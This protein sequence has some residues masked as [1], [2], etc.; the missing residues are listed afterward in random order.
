MAAACGRGAGC[1]AFP[2]SFLSPGPSRPSGQ[3]SS[4]ARAAGQ[5]QGGA[6]GGT[7]SRCGDRGPPGVRPRQSQKESA[8]TILPLAWAL[9]PAGPEVGC[10]FC[11]CCDIHPDR[12]KP[13]VPKAARLTVRSGKCS[14]VLRGQGGDLRGVPR[15]VKW[16]RLAEE[17]LSCLCYKGTSG[18]P[19]CPCQCS[20]PSLSCE[21]PGC[22]VTAGGPGDCG[23]QAGSLAPQATALPGRPPLWL[24]RAVPWHWLHATCHP[25]PGTLLRLAA[26]PLAYLERWSLRGRG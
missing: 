24:P 15:A 10:H 25:R 21:H 3:Q 12:G 2:V 11:G 8:P 18:S 6:A 20:V 16:G 14:Q 17:R 22:Q 9:R 26:R 1:P 7:R 19:D 13:A 23:A 4:S 5:A